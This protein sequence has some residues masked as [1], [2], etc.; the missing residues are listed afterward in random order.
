MRSSWPLYQDLEPAC[1]D[2]YHFWLQRGSFEVQFGSLSLAR[3]S[4]AQAKMGD[5]ARDHRVHTEWAYYLLKSAWKNPT[6]TDAPERVAE[7]RQILSDYIQGYGDR[8]PYPW[9]VYGSQLLGWIR[10]ASLSDDERARELRAVIE[11]VKAG[12]AKH[13]GYA[14]LRTLLRDLEHDLLMLS[15]PPERRVPR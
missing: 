7:G 5:G 9:H 4:L 2:D 13:P 11:V 15:V 14:D 8:D 6:A 3:I 12:N 1:A 10:V